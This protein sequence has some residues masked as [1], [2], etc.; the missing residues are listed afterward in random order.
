MN[1]AMKARLRRLA[2]ACTLAGT[3]AA[4]PASAPW[5][6][7]T[8]PADLENGAK[9]WGKCKACHTYEKDGRHIV[10]PNLWGIFGRTAGTAEGYAY[11]EAMRESGV[12]WTEETLD[13]YLAATQDYMPGSKMYGGLAIDQERKDLIAWLKSVTEE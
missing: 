9:L 1:E 5:A 12:V 8:K 11:S 4:A 6:A 2:L 13:A 3:L 7:E 10:G